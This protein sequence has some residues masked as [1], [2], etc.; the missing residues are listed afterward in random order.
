MTTKK[1]APGR[2]VEQTP[3][4]TEEIAGTIEITDDVIATIAGVAARQIPGISSLGRS[5]F[6]IFVEKPTDGVQVEVGREE[7]AVDLEV[8]IDFGCDL[9]RVAMRLRR[10]VAEAVDRMSG[11]R[12]VEVNLRV[13][14]ITEQD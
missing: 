10:A 3:R 2:V 11:K 6:S 7:A 9:R 4:G 8:I 5:W 13:I 14:G 1:K 12:V